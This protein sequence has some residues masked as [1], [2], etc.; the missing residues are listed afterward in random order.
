MKIL[1]NH[2]QFERVNFFL[3]GR[4]EVASLEEGA[5]IYGGATQVG[6]KVYSNIEKGEEI[7]LYNDKNEVAIYVPS[8]IN[9]NE[10]VDNKE[11]VA[12][13]R[14]MLEANFGETRIEDT[15]GS[16]FSE[17]NNEVVVEDITIVK[18]YTNQLTTSQINL[19]TFIGEFVKE[20]MT[21]EGVSV[22]INDS[23]MIV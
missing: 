16:W 6:T 8:T 22:T 7:T 15:K 18:A 9:V 23:L 12:I 3:G 14:G 21:Q 4:K 20:R 11:M 1:V 13:V 2:K 5:K 19:L 17:D 10:V